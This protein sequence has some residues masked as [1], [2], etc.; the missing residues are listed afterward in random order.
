[1]TDGYGNGV[2]VT[3]TGDYPRNYVN[4]EGGMDSYSVERGDTLS[5]ISGKKQIYGDW[6]MWPLIYDANK[7]TIKDPDLIHPQQ[8]LGIPRD[9]TPNERVD[10]RNRAVNRPQP[11]R[12][13][14]GR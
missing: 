11:M 6:K 12:L 9:Y 2:E 3:A 8:R 10:A 13:N 7:A 5:G 4:R 14:D 1:M